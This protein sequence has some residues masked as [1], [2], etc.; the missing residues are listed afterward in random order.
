MPL[1]LNCPSFLACGRRAL[2]AC[3]EEEHGAREPLKLRERLRRIEERQ[4]P[5]NRLQH[6]ASGTAHDDPIPRGGSNPCCCCNAINKIGSS[7][8]LVL[9]LR[10]CCCCC[11]CCCQRFVQGSGQPFIIDR[12]ELPMPPLSTCG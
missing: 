9:H 6:E 12:Q 3:A 1:F 8:M 10:C 4:R 5:V 7:A 11:C 2:E